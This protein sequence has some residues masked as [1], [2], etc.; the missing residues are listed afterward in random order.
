MTDATGDGSPYDPSDERRY[1]NIITVKVVD[2]GGRTVCR[3][4]KTTR[5]DGDGNPESTET[6][7]APS[8]T[9]TRRPPGVAFQ[10]DRVPQSPE[11]IRDGIRYLV[12]PGFT[13]PMDNVAAALD[14]IAAALNWIDPQTG[15]VIISSGSI[16]AD[17]ATLPLNQLR[18]YINS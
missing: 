16:G 1:T 6:W 7:G 10:A 17:T 4:Q 15:D 14:R 2:A 8:K 12:L 18:R 13:E 5:F 11:V 9:I 3:L